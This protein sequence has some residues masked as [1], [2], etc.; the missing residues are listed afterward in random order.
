MIKNKKF[1]LLKGV[2]ANT[3]GTHCKEPLEEKLANE[4][5]SIMSFDKCYHVNASNFIFIHFRGEKKSKT[6]EMDIK[7]KVEAA[8]KK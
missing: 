2:W 5:P 1:Y 3:F 7:E 4:E 6:N 8:F